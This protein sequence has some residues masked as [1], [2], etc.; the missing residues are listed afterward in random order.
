MVSYRL[1][2]VC[3]LLLVLIL[4][5]EIFVYNV[6]G[7]HLRSKSCKKCSRQRADQNTL[8]MTKNGSHSSTGSGQEQTSKAENIDDFRPTSPG[9]SPGVGHSIKN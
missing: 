2:N 3:V 7:R 4:C 1:K 8:K 6:E 9:H 5:Q